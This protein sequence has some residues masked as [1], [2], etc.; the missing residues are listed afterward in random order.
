MS[1]LENSEVKAQTKTPEE[2]LYQKSLF[3]GA[4]KL[5]YFE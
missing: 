2:K 5:F 4:G 1:P 3:G